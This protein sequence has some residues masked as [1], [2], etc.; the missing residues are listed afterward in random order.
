MTV[1]PP[2]AS[3]DLAAHDALLTI[4][5]DALAVNYGRYRVLA[6]GAEVAG[7]IKA[8]AYG[9]GLAPVARALAAEGCTRFFVANVHE[10]E[11]L[12]AALPDAVIYTL[13]GLTEEAAKIC[14]RFGLHPCLGSL[15]D[16]EILAR[17][18]RSLGR[19]LPAALH[20]DTGLNRLGFDR[21]ETAKLI[22]DRTL[23]N[24]ID[25]SLVMSHL[26]RSDEPDE[27]L[28]GLQL[29]RFK[30]IRAAFLDVPASFANSAGVLL[31]RDYAFDLVRPGFAIYGGTPVD[32]RASP[33]L[34]V[35]KAEARVLQIRTVEAG[36]SAGYNSTWTAKG[37]ARLAILAVGYADGYARSLSSDKNA[38]RVWLGGYYAPVAGR[39]S[40]DLLTVDVSHIP[41]NAFKCGDMAE[42][43]GPHVTLDEVAAKAKTNGYEVLTRLGERYKRHYTGKAATTES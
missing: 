4:N 42:L 5:L 43:I 2:L 31:A 38:G 7:V 37:P 39:V 6:V 20:F 28:N 24:G 34:P 12:R 15:R 17:L 35:V 9:L 11:K 36:D 25:V 19:P 29:S 40:M 26:A 27:E 22:A 3:S 13:N 16:V 8:N 10:G 32:G 14:A 30:A 33:V 1:F 41:I 18:A 23:L 21:A